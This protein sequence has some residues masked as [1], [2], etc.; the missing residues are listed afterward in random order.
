MAAEPNHKRPR[1]TGNL[2]A[3]SKTFDTDHSTANDPLR[4]W[5]SLAAGIKPSR[6][7]APKRGWMR[8][9]RR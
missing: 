3:A 7:R 8:G 9:V 1:Q 5:F 4:G 2:S 6:A